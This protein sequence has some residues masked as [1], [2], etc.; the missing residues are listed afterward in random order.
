[1]LTSSFRSAPAAALTPIALLAALLFTVPVTHAQPLT[2]VAYEN[3]APLGPSVL[4]AAETAPSSAALLAQ[5]DDIVATLFSNPAHAASMTR[6]PEQA[7]ADFARFA[8]A[9]TATTGAYVSHD[10]QGSETGELGRVYTY[11]EVQFAKDTVLLRLT[12]KGP[13]L[14]TVTRGIAPS[15]DGAFA[16]N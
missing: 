5:T 9:T 12:W 10:V 14:I 11:A 16:S 7:A 3:A 2:A 8:L 15:Q 4:V 13:H 6:R 1:M